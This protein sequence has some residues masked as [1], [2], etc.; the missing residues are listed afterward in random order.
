M[1]PRARGF[2]CA[3][4][5]E[6]APRWASEPSARKSV[7]KCSGLWSCQIGAAPTRQDRQVRLYVYSRETVAD[8]AVLP[9]ESKTMEE[10]YDVALAAL[11][12]ARQLAPAPHIQGNLWPK[13]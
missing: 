8:L 5:S 1:R 6:P 7:T 4:W 12:L 10:A 9:K 3:R 13:L 11:A 2:P